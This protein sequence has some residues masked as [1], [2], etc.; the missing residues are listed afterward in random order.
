VTLIAAISSNERRERHTHICL[1]TPAASIID[2]TSVSLTQP[3]FV[4]LGPPWTKNFAHYLGR[5]TGSVVIL[6]STPWN[7]EDEA[8]DQIF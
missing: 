6:L 2:S 4:K 8:S 5:T 7:A 1:P 3:V